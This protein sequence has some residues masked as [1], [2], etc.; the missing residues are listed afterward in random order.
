MVKTKLGANKTQKPF[1]KLMISSLGHTKDDVV[2]FQREGCG[3]KVY[4]SYGHPIGFYCE[5]WGMHTF[6]DF[7][8]E[9][10]LSNE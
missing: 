3:Q 5:Y 9:I 6:V 8:G 4:G 2:F 10:I 1:P 7:D